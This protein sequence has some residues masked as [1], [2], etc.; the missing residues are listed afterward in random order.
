MS[1][2]DQSNADWTDCQTG[3]VQRLVQGLQATRR[4]QTFERR[5][6]LAAAL[7]LVCVTS[8]WYAGVFPQSEPNYGGIV[9]SE[10]MQNAQKFTSK[11]LDEKTA[12]QIDIHLRQCEACR[13]QL[14]K[15]QQDMRNKMQPGVDPGTRNK[16]A[17][18]AGNGIANRTSSSRVPSLAGL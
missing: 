1:A 11:T 18:S 6:T 17:G 2:S 13:K 7:V 14:E 4:A 15:M 3:E 8:A 12:E 10:A 16:A 9:C 5:T